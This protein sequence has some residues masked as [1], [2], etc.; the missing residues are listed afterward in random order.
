[1]RHFVGGQ[2]YSGALEEA[3]RCCA[4]ALMATGY[5]VLVHASVCSIQRILPHRK[6]AEMQDEAQRRVKHCIGFGSCSAVH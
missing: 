5:C 2:V 1:M 4:C 6:C 3:M